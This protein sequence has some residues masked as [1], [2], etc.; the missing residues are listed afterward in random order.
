MLDKL[1]RIIGLSKTKKNPKVKK[2]QVAP[3]KSKENNK[4]KTKKNN[5]IRKKISK[6]KNSKQKI[7]EINNKKI[8]KQLKKI[9]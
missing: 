9:K 5:K 4:N 8:R 3:V 6:K 2:N 1:F 7:Y